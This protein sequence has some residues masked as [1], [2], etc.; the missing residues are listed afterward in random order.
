MKK[1]KFDRKEANPISLTPCLRFVPVASAGTY[2]TFSCL[3]FPGAPLP[4]D[5]PY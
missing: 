3:L 5:L 4:R 1:G 2:P